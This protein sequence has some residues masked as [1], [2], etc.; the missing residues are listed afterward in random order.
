MASDLDP[1]IWGPIFWSFLHTVASHAYPVTPNPTDKKHFYDFFSNLYLFLPHRKSK[2]TYAKLLHQY[3]VTAYMD[4]RKSL[5]QWVH[6]IHN[7]VNVTLQKSRLTFRELQ[8]N[9]QKEALKTKSQ[10]SKVI[11]ILGICFVIIACVYAWA[12]LKI[13][14]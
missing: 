3:P 9:K 10:K 8:E 12:F 2:D 4:S 7:K 13:P 11:I 5:E 1:E 6:F 14:V